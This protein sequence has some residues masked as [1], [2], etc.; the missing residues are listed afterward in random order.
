MLNII[1]APYDVCDRGESITK[2]VV[3]YLKSEKVEFSVYF[4]KTLDDVKKNAEE[5]YALGELEYVVVGND[6]VINAF[7]NGVKDINKIKLGI[8]P[9][10]KDDDFAKYLG[11]SSHPVQAIKDILTKHIEAVDYLILNDQIVLNNIIVGASAEIFEIYDQYKVKNAFTE[12]LALMQ[13]GNKFEGINLSF[14]LKSGK[15]KN[16]NIF[17]L[18]ISNGG[19]ARKKELSPLANVQDGLFNFNYV[20]ILEKNER[21][22]YLK[23][24]NS[25]KQI[26]DEKT[27]QHWINQIRIT[28]EEKH[29]KAIVDGSLQTLEELN[30][31]LVEGGLKLMKNEK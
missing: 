7:L 11:L 19:L 15:V 28:N 5:I 1:V 2:K 8:V 10:S 25:G 3:S 18:S 20:S 13:Y 31:R 23:L 27:K 29:I 24:F 21:K 6:T 22:K 14:D 4:S 12:K 26:Y 30:V 17:E 16:E 9:T